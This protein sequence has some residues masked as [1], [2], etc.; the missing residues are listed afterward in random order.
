MIDIR[1]TSQKRRDE[2]ATRICSAF[3]QLSNELPGV[4]PHRIFSV[5]AEREDMTWQ[6]IK[7]VLIKHKLYATKKQK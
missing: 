1:T 3:L 5:I 4:K 7:N 2:R 6:G